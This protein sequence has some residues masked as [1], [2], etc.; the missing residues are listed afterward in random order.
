MAAIAFKEWWEKHGAYQPI[1]KIREVE[2][3]YQMCELAWDAA[4]KTMEGVQVR[5][6]NT[7]SMPCSSC[8]EQVL[9]NEDLSL[10]CHICNTRD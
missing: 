9:I 7:P 5:S 8:G 3:V 6:P 10:Y 1:G 2:T 4:I